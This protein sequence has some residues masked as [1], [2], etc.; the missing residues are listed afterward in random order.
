MEGG[1]GGFPWL[2]WSGFENGRE[3]HEVLLLAAV[4][5]WRLKVGFQWRILQRKFGIL[6]EEG[7]RWEL[8]RDFMCAFNL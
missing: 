6:K 7:R 2:S 5:Q 3:L 8:L 1:G 4:D